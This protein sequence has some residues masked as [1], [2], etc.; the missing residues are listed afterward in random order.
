MAQSLLLSDY[1]LIP[2]Y[3]DCSLNVIL[4]LLPFAFLLTLMT[5]LLGL[6]LC[7]SDLDSPKGMLFLFLC[8]LL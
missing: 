3:A 1:F 2:H 5:Q 8:F 7:S 4:L 6:A